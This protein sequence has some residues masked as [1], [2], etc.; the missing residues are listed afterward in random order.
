M[1]SEIL[2]AFAALLHAGIVA[3]GNT[4]RAAFGGDI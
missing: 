4:V 3:H 1:A 2:T